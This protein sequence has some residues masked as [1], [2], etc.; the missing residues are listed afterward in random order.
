[1]KRSIIKKIAYCGLLFVFVCGAALADR[2]VVQKIQVQGLQRITLG[3]FLNYM[4]IKEGDTFDT[5]QS[6]QVIR[7][8]YKTGFFSNVALYRQNN[9]LVVAV[10][11]RSVI[12]SIDISGNKEIPSKDLLD[13]LKQTGFAQGQVFDQ[14]QLKG[15]KQ[16][17]LDQYYNLG[18]YNVQVDTSV[19]QE[20][21]GGVAIKIDVNEGPV[22]KIKLI[23]IIGNDAFSD[24]DLLKGFSLSTPN[25]WSFFTKAD[26]YSKDKLNADLETLRSYYMDRG[27]LEFKVA[28]AQVSITPDKKQVYITVRVIEGPIYK[29]SGVKL[30]GDLLGKDTQIQNLVSIKSGDVFSRQRL[31]DTV[32][33]ITVFLGDYGYAYPNIK[34]IPQVDQQKHMV[35]VEFNVNPGQRMYVRRVDYTGNT[36]TQDE[37]LRREMRQFEGAQ[38]VLSSI[39]ESERRLNNLGYVSDVKS[40]LKPV[41]D[42]PDQIDIEYQL[43]EQSSA[44]ASVSAGYSDADG[45]IASAS[46]SDQ[47]FFGTGNHVGVSASISQYSSIVS[48]NYMNPYFTYNG[49]SAETSVYA[50]MVDP[51]HF[52]VSN[53]ATQVFGIMEHFGIPLT[54]HTRFRAG[55]GF[56]HTKV[57]MGSSDVG[58]EEQDYINE[59]G[60]TYDT[61]KLDGTW[62]YSNLDR[63]IFPSRGF[64][65]SLGAELG[66]P[67]FSDSLKYYKLTY[68][69]V[70][71]QPLLKY[72]ILYPRV[73]AGYANGYGEYAG[74]Y[75]FFENF[76]AGGLGSVRGYDDYSLGPQDSAGN[77]LGGNIALNGSVNLSFP[78]P[79][80]NLLRTSVFMDAGSVFEDKVSWQDIKYTVGFQMEV[81]YPLPMVASFGFPVINYHSD[82]D[83]RQIFQFTIGFSI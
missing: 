73:F 12:S 82:E 14:S 44:T 17:L 20:G 29:F 42:H 15:I 63:A 7:V 49:V 40:D 9:T 30:S 2:F 38:Y 54:A 33:R 8:L 31:I 37:V 28:S 78:N 48:L 36:K 11:E 76:F 13:G 67:I 65:T 24:K 22:A 58:Q 55:F 45:F 56:E 60:D 32:N 50:Q 69:A 80:P 4:P 46:V 71:Y 25:L 35:F 72:F 53:Y 74:N 18:H 83:H 39:K 57:R 43:K 79:W 47:N 6:S 16:A 19:T 23:R 52:D 61:F 66:L 34:P 5:S 75:P 70:Y 77:S 81:R 27:Y 51:S 10:T 41:P 64:S 68:N 59:F 26:Q 3:T 62:I 1:M 21:K